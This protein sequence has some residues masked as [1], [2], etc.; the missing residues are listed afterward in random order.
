MASIYKYY[1]PPP[2]HR[3]NE[4]HSLAVGKLIAHRERGRGLAP[5]GSAWN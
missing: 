4:F 5:I 3:A 2:S 1:S